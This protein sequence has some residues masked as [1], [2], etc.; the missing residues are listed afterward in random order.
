[1]VSWAA[2]DRHLRRPRRL[3]P[4]RVHR[5]VGSPPCLP[6][7][8]RLLTGFT[9]SDLSAT[10]F[11]IIKDRL[12]TDAPHSSRR[13]ASQTVLFE[14]LQALPRL[15]A[16]VT[17]F[18]A[19]EVFSYMQ[20]DATRSVFEEGYRKPQKEWNNPEVAALWRSDGRG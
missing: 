4:L 9:V 11:D 1:M 6:H 15:V 8:H 18:L 14:V 20:K 2:V 7:S 19:E 12:Y 13:R 16:P 10:Y 3:R 5:R 17:P